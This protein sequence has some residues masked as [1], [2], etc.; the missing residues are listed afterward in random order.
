MSHLS[1]YDGNFAEIHAGALCHARIPIPQINPG[2]VVNHNSVFGSA[3]MREPC[4]SYRTSTNSCMK[5]GIARKSG[6]KHALQLVGCA[7]S[8][9]GVFFKPMSILGRR[10]M[11]SGKG[12]HGKKSKIKPRRWSLAKQT[13][14]ILYH[15]SCKHCVGTEVFSDML[16]TLSCQVCTIM[17]VMMMIISSYLST[18][19]TTY[20]SNSRCQWASTTLLVLISM[21]HSCFHA[22][23]SSMVR[24][25]FL[26]VTLKTGLACLLRICT[27]YFV[28]G[29]HTYRTG[30]KGS[31][32][33]TTRRSTQ[34]FMQYDTRTSK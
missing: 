31:G 20:I 14:T 33:P 2:L 8:Y 9:F 1:G 22:F 6:N 32:C 30:R 21:M 7:F 25:V 3:T 11:M 28:Q 17:V 26:Y 18:C 15:L 19:K 16:F 5:N 10:F 27:Q 23:P 13:S 4:N 29:S 34:D 24:T 12:I